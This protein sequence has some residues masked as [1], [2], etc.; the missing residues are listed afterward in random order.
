ME[1]ELRDLLADSHEHGDETGKQVPG[2]GSLRAKVVS[3]VVAVRPD[4][5]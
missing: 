1:H 4:V 5:Y 2:L 3:V